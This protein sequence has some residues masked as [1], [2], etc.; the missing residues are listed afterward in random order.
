MALPEKATTV[1]VEGGRTV[2]TNGPYLGTS[3]RVDGTPPGGSGREQD[4]A[5]WEHHPWTGAVPTTVRSFDDR[6]GPHR[7]RRH[8]AHGRRHR[9]ESESVLG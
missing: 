4:R 1:Q 5:C 3:P 8:T 7:E 2:T 9:G 6:E